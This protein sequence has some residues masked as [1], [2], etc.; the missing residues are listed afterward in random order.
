MD[1]N[2]DFVVAW[3]V[4][5]TSTYLYGISGPAVQPRRNGPGEHDQHQSRELAT[6]TAAEFPKV[7]M[8]SAGDF[9]IA[10]QGYDAKSRRLRRSGT[11]A[12]GVAQGSTFRREQQHHADNQSAPVDRDGFRAAT[13]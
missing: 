13:S 12:S 3:E 1:A 10:Y 7:A 4:L 11:T 5:N 6:R 8:D 9:A 2:G